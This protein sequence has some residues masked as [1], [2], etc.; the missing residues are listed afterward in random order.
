MHYCNYR[1]VIDWDKVQTLEDIKAIVKTL[2]MDWP[3]GGAPS[4]IQHLTKRQDMNV[5]IVNL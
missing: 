4:Q 1:Q 2:N 5:Q 3:D